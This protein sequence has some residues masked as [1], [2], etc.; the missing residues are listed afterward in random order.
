MHA[1]LIE[2]GTDGASALGY[3][4]VKLADKGILAR[5]GG[6]NAA[7]LQQHSADIG[8]AADNMLGADAI[9]QHVFCAKAVLQ[10]HHRS[11]GANKLAALFHGL[12]GVERLAQNDDQVALTNAIWRG[13]TRKPHGFLSCR[14]Y[15]DQAFFVDGIHVRSA[16]HEMNLIA[17]FRQRTADG[18]SQRASP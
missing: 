14:R 11:V 15:H 17:G 2:R 3:A 1:R 13:V 9:A 5:D 18:A 6:L 16:S 4:A 12:G 10:R 8:F 7:R